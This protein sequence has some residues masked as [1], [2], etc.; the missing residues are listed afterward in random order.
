MTSL[1]VLTIGIFLFFTGRGIWRGF[2]NE[3][4]GLLA[5][6]AGYL[7][8]GQLSNILAPFLNAFIDDEGL[9]H[10]VAYYVSLFGIYLGVVLVGK[11]A[12]R[13][14]KLILLGWL[15]RLLGA[16][17][18]MAKGLLVAALVALPLRW[19]GD[20]FTSI[21][22]SAELRAQS[23]YYSYALEFGAWLTPNLFRVVDGLNS[24]ED[25]AF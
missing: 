23:T 21:G 10:G 11:I 12:T 4:A 19:I 7:F 8:A 5:L 14:S 9:L 22:P 3:L 20:E 1:D 17:T 25:A 24:G 2:I 6:V 16:F 13:L 15:N 18:G